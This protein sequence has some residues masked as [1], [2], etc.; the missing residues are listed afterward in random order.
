MVNFIFLIA[1]MIPQNEKLSIIDQK[2]FIQF[3][4]LDKKKNTEYCF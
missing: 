2:K 4:F 1:P 3:I